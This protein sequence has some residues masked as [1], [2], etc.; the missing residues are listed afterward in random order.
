MEADLVGTVDSLQLP[1][2]HGLWPVFEAI[3]NAYDAIAERRQLD[4]T[5]RP[6]IEVTIHRSGPDLRL[7]GTGPGTMS[8]AVVS[9]NGV[10][11]TDE[12]WNAFNKLYTR[13]KAKL[14]GKGVGRL[15]W[16]KVFES[17]TVQ[18][19][20]RTPKGLEQRSFRFSLPQ[21]ITG[22]EEGLTA[23][24]DA[25][26]TTVT[27]TALKEEFRDGLNVK[28]ETL[29]R[30]IVEHF[31]T[32][33]VLNDEVAVQFVDGDYSRSL[34]EVYRDIVLG[35]AVS[36][37]VH[38]KGEDIV[39]QHFLIRGY[40]NGKHELRWCARDRVVTP[41]TLGDVP[42]LGPRIE[43]EGQ[44]LIYFC[45]V[46]SDLL[47]RAANQDRTRFSIPETGDDQRPGLSDLRGAVR[48][49]VAE[50]LEPLL[51]DRRASIADRLNRFSADA[52]QYRSIVRRHADRL[53]H[54]PPDIDDRRLEV[55]LAKV[56][57]ELVY[58]TREE[59]RKIL[60]KGTQPK[61]EKLAE[62]T[63]AITETQR[64]DLAGYV[65]HRRIVLDLMR[66]AL[67]FRAGTEQ[68]PFEK[69]VHRLIFPM[70]A[71]SDDL[72]GADDEHNLWVID[73]RLAFYSF[74]ASDQEF[75]R[76]DLEVAPEGEDRRPDLI[77]LDRV[78][79][80][81]FGDDLDLR[82][83]TLVE[84]KR[85]E[86]METAKDDPIQRLIE[87][88]RL[89]RDGKIRRRDGLAVNV[90][91]AVPIYAFAI[92]NVTAAYRQI[93]EDTYKASQMADDTWFM[94]R[95]KLRLQVHVVPY[96]VAVQNAEKRNAVFF[97]RVGLSTVKG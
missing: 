45:Y 73:E 26:G 89:I 24:A 41:D 84:F 67:K 4:P 57:A 70:K 48:S 61:P 28:P 46:T 44:H 43:H 8:G 52:P 19:V 13:H 66:S 20:T 91:E 75:H 56:K 39:V 47:T 90:P 7:P 54:I 1:R 21:G 82:G 77:A 17:A 83:I 14:G 34:Q 35:D 62:L 30:R 11:L 81:G 5:F 85:A 33:F 49:A 63:A 96:T 40:P 76:T 64:S 10:G 31:L 9:D 25:L 87:Y 93:L 58:D 78:A 6:R 79:A 69:D 80:Y 36:K 74:L 97:D 15:T 92:C 42:G 53:S 65:A 55:E 32:T 37:T 2:E 50:F 51:A 72:T 60:E 94:T 59:A 12:N 22:I 23:S 27:L 71:S 95:E 88:T 86:G 38:V 29:A 68:Y 3:H 16:L 18:S